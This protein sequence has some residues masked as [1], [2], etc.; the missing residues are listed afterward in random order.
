MEDRPIADSILTK[1]NTAQKNTDIQQ[2]SE[3]NSNPRI[4]YV[5][6]PKL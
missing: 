1:I 4:Q 3:R 2:F 6:D 5:G